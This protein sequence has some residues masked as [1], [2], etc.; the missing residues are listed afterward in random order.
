[1][2][3][4]G[5]ILPLGALVLMALVLVALL[6]TIERWMLHRTIRKAID[7]QPEM[8]ATLAAKLPEAGRR[9]GRDAT[10][11]ALFAA[12]AAIAIGA[13]LDPGEGRIEGLQIALV[14]LAIGIAILGHFYLTRPRSD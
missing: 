13:A 8:V 2:T 10:G 14:P 9:W 6:K 7:T 11:W 4:T 12:G 5:L 3:M 1:M